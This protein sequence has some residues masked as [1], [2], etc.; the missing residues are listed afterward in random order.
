MPLILHPTNF[1][2]FDKTSCTGHRWLK[3]KDLFVFCSAKNTLGIVSW[4]FILFFCFTSSM[5]GT[6]SKSPYCR[7][8]CAGSPAINKIKMVKTKSGFLTEQLIKRLYLIMRVN[9]GLYLT[10]KYQV[11]QF[12]FQVWH[13]CVERMRHL[14]H[15]R[16]HIR[17][18]VLKRNKYYKQGHLSTVSS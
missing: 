17:A 8:Q 9:S 18:E 14:L 11:W 5:S 12:V 16:W 7:E 13:C 15:V 6:R 4:F 10:L 2:F 1:G 3:T